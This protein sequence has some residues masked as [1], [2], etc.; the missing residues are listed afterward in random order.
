MS[1]T[2]PEETAEY[3]KKRILVLNARVWEGVLSWPAV[4]N[5]LKNFTGVVTNEESE[6]L[7]ALYWL[8][9]FMYFGGR[10]I[11][12]LLRALYRDLFLLPLI[13]ELKARFPEDDEAVLSARVEE[14]LAK[15]R[16]VGVGNPSES[17]VHLLYFFRQENNL[18]KTVFVESMRIFR[19]SRAKKPWWKIWGR[20]RTLRDPSITRYVFLDDICGSGNTAVDYSEEV[21]EPLFQLSPSATVSY[22]CLFASSAGLKTIREKTK[23]GERCGAVYEMDESYRCLSEDSRYLVHLPVGIDPGVARRL[24]EVYGLSVAGHVDH[25]CGY[26]DSQM[27]LGCHH[28]T[29][30]NTLPIMWHDSAAFG[31]TPWT[32]IFRRYPKIYGG[33]A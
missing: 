13:H 22:F 9:Q 18:P 1:P 2:T 25:A 14:E 28:N 31:G 20:D 21:I 8:S 24:V 30:D 23:F 10:E 5:W 4:E 17:G 15:T 6:R 33:S 16:F 19:R 26:N 12:V 27:L 32:P 11:R 7:H 29:P 3:L